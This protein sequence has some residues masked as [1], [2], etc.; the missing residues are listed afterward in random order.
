MM[1]KTGKKQKK[2]LRAVP[3][4]GRLLRLGQKIKP[5]LTRRNQAIF[6][7]LTA[8]FF[9]ISL[10]DIIA[11]L[12]PHQLRIVIYV[13]AAICFFASCTLWVRAAWRLFQLV[14]LPFALRDQRI[15]ALQKDYR[16]LTVILSLPGLGMGAVFALFNGGIAISS[17]SA[18]HG[19]LAVYYMLLFSIRLIAVLYAKSVYLDCR[20][21]EQELREWRVCRAC[22][23]LLAVLSLALAGT[24]AVLVQGMGG[25]HYPGALIYAAAAYTFYKLIMSAISLARAH[26]EKSPLAMTLRCICHSESLVSLLSLQTAMFAQFGSFPDSFAPRMNLVTGGVVCLAALVI[27][28]S[29]AWKANRGIHALKRS[30]GRAD[31]NTRLT[32]Y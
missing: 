20:V 19:A 22:G 25:R 4:R 24:V 17:Q 2:V 15:Q 27:G 23:I 6:F 14:L 10:A 21:E 18:W 1:R 13:C 5:L 26:R 28:I 16:L 30:T 3:I 11:G 31:L 9:I 8:L 12:F 7:A 29:M 32:I